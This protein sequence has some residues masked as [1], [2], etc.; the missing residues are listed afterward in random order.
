M[1]AATHLTLLVPE[2]LRPPAPA[3]FADAAAGDSPTL[4]R[5]LATSRCARAPAQAF[6]TVLA[7]LFGWRGARPPFAALRRRGDRLPVEEGWLCA[8]PVHLRLLQERMV[9][10][11]SRSFA[12]ADDEATTLVAAL[13]AHFAGHAQFVAGAAD[14]WYL[15]LPE[16]GDGALEQPP[17][18]AIAGRGLRRHLPENAA[19]TRWRRLLLEAQMLLAAHALNR[20]RSER[21][22]LP[23]NSLWLW[24]DA[25]LAASATAPAF[26]TVAS[27]SALARGLADLAGAATLALPA[28]ADAWLATLPAVATNPATPSGRHLVVCESLLAPALYDDQAAWNDALA[29]L[30]ANWF[31]PLA[32]ALAA[33]RLAG[34]DIVAPT[35]FGV[36]Q[37]S[38]T[39]SGRWQWWRRPRTLAQLAGDFAAADEK[40]GGDHPDRNPQ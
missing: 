13:N 39:R 12:L 14:R 2:L 7:G 37:W 3:G 19:A 24:G 16:A 9:L 31:A 35:P 23:I 18:S 33:G 20:A 5:L 34:I 1:S 25:P 28:G 11:D 27:D 10:A 26:A 29:A 21:G 4:A 36:V 15:R 38:V 17:L 6:E 40:A 22:E 30:D 32:A 8:D